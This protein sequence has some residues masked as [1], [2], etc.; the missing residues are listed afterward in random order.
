MPP[1]LRGEELAAWLARAGQDLR[2]AEVDLGA[3]PP[4]LADA[5]FHCQQAVE[6]A[7]KALLT[8]HDHPFR[9]THDIGELA[10]ACLEHEPQLE[11]LLRGSAPMTE[12]VWRF[13]YPGEPFE[14]EREEVEE[15]LGLARRVVAK[16]ERLVARKR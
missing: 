13:R 9:R 16:V 5:A 14:P 15:A 12:Y 4:L 2:A 11:A 8:R 1:D 3:E 6:K 7:L 10:M